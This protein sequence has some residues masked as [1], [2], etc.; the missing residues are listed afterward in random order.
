[1]NGERQWKYFFAKYVDGFKD[2]PQNLKARELKCFTWLI[3]ESDIIFLFELP[4]YSTRPIHQ[5][6]IKD[7]RALILQKSDSVLNF[8]TFAPSLFFLDYHMI[9]LLASRENF[10][11]SCF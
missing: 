6:S 10:F 4:Y 7:A 9:T 1:M 5:D 11:S 8:S 3:H 2:N